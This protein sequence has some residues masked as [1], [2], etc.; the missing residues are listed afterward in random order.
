MYNGIPTSLLSFS[1]SFSKDTG[2]KERNARIILTM[3]VFDLANVYTYYCLDCN[4][5]D[6]AKYSIPN[7]R[8]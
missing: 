6:T 8:Y 2:F 4:F 1:F 3:R 5:F 7:L